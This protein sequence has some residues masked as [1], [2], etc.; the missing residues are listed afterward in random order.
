MWSAAAFA[1]VPR[2]FTIRVLMMTRRDRKADSLSRL[3]RTLPAPNPR[4]I[5]LPWN[6]L[7]PAGAEGAKP[8]L[9]VALVSHGATVAPR[10]MAVA[11]PKQM[12]RQQDDA[13]VAPSLYLA[14]PQIFLCL[15]DSGALSR[16]KS[17][18]DWAGTAAQRAR[19][20]CPGTRKAPRNV[21]ASVA[22]PREESG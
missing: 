17:F 21:P 14:L 16:R 15:S 6:L 1:P 2:I 18:N 4:A 7:V 22:Q 19:C 11:P 10:E 3:A 12:C 13:P 5:R 9:E 20:A 8:G